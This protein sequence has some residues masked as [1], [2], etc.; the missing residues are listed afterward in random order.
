MQGFHCLKSGMLPE[1]REEVRKCLQLQQ[2]QWIAK[3]EPRTPTHYNYTSMTTTNEGC[4]STSTI[5][6]INSERCNVST[7]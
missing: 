6:I 1:S 2:V 3:T 5:N 7:H 4:N